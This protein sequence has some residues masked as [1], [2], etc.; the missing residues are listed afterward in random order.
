[1]EK[2]KIIAIV[3]ILI[4]ALAAIAA[5]VVLTSN[6]GKDVSVTGVSLDK[7][8]IALDTGSETRLTPT[9]SPSDATN[10]NVIWKSSNTSVATVS[11]GVVKAVSA[12]S[13]T[14]TVTTDDGSKTATCKVTVSTPAT[15]VSVTGVELDK[16]TMA[17]TKGSSSSLTAT[18]LPSNATNKNVT[19]K[20][21][22]T[23]VATVSNG[24]VTGVSEGTAVITVTTDDGAKTATCNVTVNKD[25]NGIVLGD[26]G[27]YVPIYG[28]ANNDLYID[29]T[30][31][32]MINSIIA[33]TT[34]YNSTNMPFADANLDGAIDSKDVEI[35][36]NI[37]SR[38]P[39]EV[40]YQDYYGDATPVN[41]PLTN[42]NIAVTYYQQAE[43]CAILGVLDDVKVA[44]KAATV[45]GTMW[46]TLS[47]GDTIEWGTTGSSAITDD[48]VEKFI[49]NGVSLVVCTPRTEN[50]DLAVRLHS[51]RNIDFIQL[52]Y[53]GNY[54]LSTIQT[55]GILMDKEDKS[56]AY[57]EYC[58]KVSDL[59]TSKITD[60]TSKNFLVMDKY[61]VD[62][63]KLEL[64]ANERHG[65][66]VLVDKYL[67][68]A[69][70]EDGTNQF[71]FVNHNLEWL[72]ANSDKFDYIIFA[73][74]GISGY[75]DDQTTGT[76]Y[77]QEAYNADFESQIE[78]FT[79][80]KAYKNGNIVGSSYP[81][82]FGY[83][84]YAILPLIAAQVYPDLISID[85]ARDL[86]QEW[87]DNYNVVDIDV[88]TQGA[89]SYTGSA[90]QTSYPKLNSISYD[91][92]TL[93]EIGTYVPIYGNA[94]NDLFIDST[95]VS[96][97]NS[98]IAGTTKYNSTNM[99][100]ADA[101]LDGTIDSKDVEIVRNIISRT[102]CEVFYQDYYGDAT[103]VNFPLTNRNIAVTYYQQAEACAIL[104]VLDDIKVASKA[105]TV[106]GTMWPT[107]SD[108]DTIEWGTTG[109]SAITDDAVEKFIA[110]GVSLVVCTPRTENHD[111]AVRL[112]NE[113][114]ID[115]IQLWYNGNYCLSTIQTM[116]I[117]MDKEDK[118][119]AYMEYCNEIGDELKSKIGDANKDKSILVISGYDAS[120]DQISILANE[121]HGSYVL[122]N[123]YLGNC[124]YEDG[125]NQ[126]GFVYHNVE[127]LVANSSKFDYIVF[128]MSGNSGYADDQSTGTYY[129]HETYNKAFETAISNFEKTNAY[130]NGNIVGSEYPNTFGYSAYPL[131][132]VIAAQIYPDEFTL[133]DALADLQEWFDNYN[134][135]SLDVNKDGAISYTGTEY[136]VSYPQMDI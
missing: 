25:Y 38:T 20:S 10:K 39:C 6:N 75:A 128:C 27:T 11:N 2:N 133:E 65:S 79:K 107:L 122:I 91:D 48:A 61:Y 115:F 42:R 3:A 60:T 67:G 53:N 62:S 132:K 87:F 117:L 54:C 17:I 33:G 58:N 35:V 127:W 103:P 24:T 5:A 134:V 64:M 31:V 37:I 136:K 120:K 97:L 71:G 78:P 98:I 15:T 43:A 45:Y 102:P 131:M 129:T 49:A 96:M 90:Y 84:A 118:S 28:N 95:D 66:Y 46:P 30:D 1:M 56:R 112:H 63:D 21:S 89:V 32:E 93:G 94:N 26:I 135:V 100:F 69:Y 47:D 85:D 19:W 16:S 88:T 12:G 14:I 41:F 23:S 59:L 51:E 86:L 40:F 105:A 36:R 68:N 77:T 106:Y 111:L 55:M 52:W 74:S 76:Y 73:K 8:S 109:S 92:V 7:T 18:V 119:R 29:G 81:N 113:Q 82:I 121:R 83:S 116:G 9:I 104:G 114:N 130:K 22:N 80:V 124:Y 50:H 70:Y 57:M 123:K 13:A 72:V 44:S 110:N 99:P 4:V 125:T 126:F 108:S 34:K 101:N